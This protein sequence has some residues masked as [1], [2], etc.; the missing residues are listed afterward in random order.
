MRR[1]LGFLAW[2]VVELVQGFLDVIGHGKVH[3]SGFVVPRK[4][5]TKVQR[6]TPIRCDG[7][8]AG[9]GVHQVLGILF[10]VILDTEIV[11]NQGKDCWFCVMFEQARSV[12]G[13]MV[14]RQGKVLDKALMC[15]DSGLGKSI[16][17]FSNLH[18]H[19]T[20]VHKA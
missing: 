8:E 6:A 5:E 15:Q 10:G 4:R 2:N 19:L 17:S 12:L 13:W 14:A 9:Q 16:H 7:V 11:H 20:I 18:H 1:V 3:C